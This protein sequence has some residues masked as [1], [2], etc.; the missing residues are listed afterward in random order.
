MLLWLTV[1]RRVAASH[2]KETMKHGLFLFP[3]MLTC[4]HY[5]AA[6]AR[7]YSTRPRMYI[8]HSHDP[9]FNLAWEDFIFRTTHGETP[10]C[11]VYV[12][13]PCVVVGRNQSL[14]NEVDPR[15][16]HEQGVPIVRRLSGGG[17]VYHDLG[18]LNF[19]FHTSK[20]HFVRATHTELMSRA[21]RA[22]PV[23]LPDRFGQPP[24][25][26]TRRNDLAVYDEHA[27]R[28]ADMYVRKV[29][30]SA[31]KLANQRAYHHGTL[32]VRADLT[33][34]SVLK[35]RRTHIRSNAVASVPSPVANLADAFREQ[36][37]RL[38]WPNIY[39]AIQKEFER[40]YG[41]CDVVEVDKSSLDATASDGRRDVCVRE[42]YND[43]HTWEWLYGSSPTFSA[44]V[45][46]Q[47]VP[48]HV[49]L[50]LTL[51]CQK[52]KVVSVEIDSPDTHTRMTAQQ[53]VGAP[54]DALAHTP[55]SCVPLSTWDTDKSLREWLRRAL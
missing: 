18:N 36:E 17:S 5:V 45:S 46:S 51:H 49:P 24:V 55:P 54:F 19:S 41:D 29:S 23:S 22:A 43:M 6:A 27:T 33:R 14:W 1:D 35:Q 50:A 44:H 52:G 10:A 47:H 3:S 9:L 39:A 25:F 20:T 31:Y 11:F 32:L 34:M 30:G 26:L 53:L 48:Y 21:L 12:N 16:M 37:A 42:T 38:T 40:A 4:R 13:D 7:H 2:V 15:K 8:S 28:A